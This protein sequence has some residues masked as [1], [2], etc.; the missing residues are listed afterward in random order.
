MLPK[1]YDPL[2]LI[3]CMLVTGKL[4]LQNVVRLKLDWD[5]PIPED[6]KSQWLKWLEC[7]KTVSD[8]KIDR[9]I[10]PREFV[11]NS[12]CE[13]HYFCDA[14]NRAY[15]VCCYVRLVNVSGEIHTRLIMSK[16]KIAPP[17]LPRYRA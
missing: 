12:V 9:C 16:G 13:L 17:I 6:I 14:S 5:V 7:L 11:N 2:G 1:L 15:S 10:R 8:V 4:L 3:Y